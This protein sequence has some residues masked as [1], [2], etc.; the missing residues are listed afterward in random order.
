[1]VNS[2]QP[3]GF[4]RISERRICCRERLLFP[5][6]ELGDD[7][8]GIVLNISQNGLALQADTELVYDDLPEIRFRFSPSLPW[9]E[10]RGR[11]AW[12]SASKKEAGIEFIGLSDEVRDQIE[13]WI[14]WASPAIQ[15][16][17]AKELFENAKQFKK[18][19]TSSE[20][21]R[22]SPDLV[23]EVVDLLPEKESEG[24]FFSFRS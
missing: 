18:R 6:A 4:P 17:N 15:F 10:V 20:T 11:I 23:P 5:R 22:T 19:K 8:R 21:R 24:S 1:M 7:N 13:T 9:V 16:P 14:S 2:F 3:G 12:R